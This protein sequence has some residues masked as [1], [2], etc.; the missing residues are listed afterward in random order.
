MPVLNVDAL[1]V[2]LIIATELIVHPLRQ[3]CCISWLSRTWSHIGMKTENYFSVQ[4]TDSLHYR[5]P[6]VWACFHLPLWHST[7][8]V[9]QNRAD[10]SCPDSFYLITFCLNCTFLTYRT[11]NTPR[12]S[13]TA[14]CA[15]SI[16][17]LN[18]HLIPSCLSKDIYMHMRFFFLRC[19]SVRLSDSSYKSCF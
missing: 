13:S 6:S 17:K 8:S 2:M 16:L 3:L 4:T 7:K 18:T 10:L 1:F 5:I 14:E 9:I 19:L 12:S 11:V 15:I